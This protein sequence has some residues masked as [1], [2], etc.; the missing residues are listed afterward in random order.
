M[1]C[2]A[3][4][5]FIMNKIVWQRNITKIMLSP[6]K[7]MGIFSK[8]QTTLVLFC[9]HLQN[10]FIILWT[11]IEGSLVVHFATPILR[12]DS[13]IDY[14]ALYKWRVPTP[15]PPIS[16]T[17]TLLHLN[18]L[19]RPLTLLFNSPKNPRKIH[20]FTGFFQGTNTKPFPSYADRYWF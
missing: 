6:N 1:Q 19:A 8:K 16:M 7:I 5:P 10:G 13:S 18:V 3:A 12:P 20:I 14:P 9:L 15:P 17:I 11:F 4:S 2:N